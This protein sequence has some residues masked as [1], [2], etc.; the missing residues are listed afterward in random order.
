M[1]K[2]HI[3]SLG[4]FGYNRSQVDTLLNERNSKINE[5]ETQ[6]ETLTKELSEASGLSI[7]S[8]N[9]I[10]SKLELSGYCTVVG[11]KI[12]NDTGRPSRIIQFDF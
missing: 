11:K 1:D 3:L 9:R 10:I 2:T 6:V 7:R 12:L 4:L 5:L 8:I